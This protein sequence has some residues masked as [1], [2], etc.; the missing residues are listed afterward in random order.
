LSLTH[1]LHGWE[2]KLIRD[3]NVEE[4][5]LYGLKA[6]TEMKSAKKHQ[7]DMEIFRQ[8]MSGVQPLKSDN[9]LAHR[10]GKPKPVPRQLQKDEA[11][12]LMELLLDADDPAEFETGEELLFLRDGYPPRL[13]QR[14]RRGFFSVNDSIDLHQLTEAI[15]HDVLLRFIADALARGQRCIHV[16]HGKGLRSRG[17]PVLKLMTRK[18]LR[19]HSAVIAFASCTPANGGTGAVDILL[20]ERRN[21][22]K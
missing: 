2:I 10:P 18:L 14:L 4:M 5:I 20:R 6:G 8:A 17:Q 13:L 9:R 15:A 3:G 12:V 11:S 7:E 1:F 22:G 16:I 21:T 19:R